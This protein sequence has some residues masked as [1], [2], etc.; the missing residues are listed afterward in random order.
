M[1]I[2]ILPP[3]CL[4][5]NCLNFFISKLPKNFRVNYISF[6]VLMAK[7][8][9][10]E[11]QSWYFHKF[12]WKLNEDTF[13]RQFYYKDALENISWNCEIQLHKYFNP[14]LNEDRRSTKGESV[15][16]VL[17]KNA[18]DIHNS[19]K[20]WK[21]GKEVEKYRYWEKCINI[22]YWRIN[23]NDFVSKVSPKKLSI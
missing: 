17:F 12:F 7:L 3:N 14:V 15:H 6:T 13:N 19:R 4:K 10:Q 23:S 5:I 22:V 20:N 16:S 21:W 8:L 9:G 18:R 2:W 1:K 11:L